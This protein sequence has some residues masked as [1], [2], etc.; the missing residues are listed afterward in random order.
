MPKAYPN[1]QPYGTK[2]T[3][4]DTKNKST[5]KKNELPRPY[6]GSAYPTEKKSAVKPGQSKPFHYN[7]AQDK[8]GGEEEKKPYPGTNTLPGQASKTPV[9]KYKPLKR[10]E[11]TAERGKVQH[12]SV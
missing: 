6:G 5:A 10:L 3:P 1:N 7:A 9:K 8:K 4:E 12:I 2:L 11:G